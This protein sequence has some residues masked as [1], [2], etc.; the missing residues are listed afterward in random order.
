MSPSISNTPRF[1]SSGGTASGCLEGCLDVALP[2]LEREAARSRLWSADGRRDRDPA[3]DR[4]RCRAEAAAPEL[5]GGAGR[6]RLRCRFGRGLCFG[7]A[8]GGKLSSLVSLGTYSLQSEA[9]NLP[10]GRF[11][12][13]VV[14]RG[15]MRAHPRAFLTDWSTTSRPWSCASRT[16][17]TWR[18]GAGRGASTLVSVRSPPREPEASC[19]APCS[20]AAGTG[21]SHGVEAAVERGTSGHRPPSV[22]AN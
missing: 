5:L 3:T 11:L 15:P 19:W 17:T 18:G 20:C 14:A 7:T 10:S 22:T 2:A 16:G 9:A 13:V 21:T 4:D 8:I 12:P 6:D 1:C